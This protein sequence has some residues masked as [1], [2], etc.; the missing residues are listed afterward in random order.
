M[1]AINCSGWRGVSEG[2]T[3]SALTAHEVFPLFLLRLTLPF[4][5]FI[6]GV[7]ST[8]AAIKLR[9]VR[10]AVALV[11]LPRLSRAVSLFCGTCRQGQCCEQRHTDESRFQYPSTSSGS[12]LVPRRNVVVSGVPIRRLIVAQRVRHVDVSA[13]SLA[14]AG[15]CELYRWARHSA[16]RAEYAAISGVR[17]KKLTAARAFVKVLARV[18]GHL[19]LSRQATFGT[20]DN[21]AR[22]YFHSHTY[23]SNVE[24]RGARDED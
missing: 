8:H 13:K 15:F 7:R 3:R 10:K 22:R 2:S 24:L 21:G 5:R 23:E 4:V 11:T 6:S 20:R 17:S 9:L 14:T 18:K 19:L 1:F 16:E 12:Y